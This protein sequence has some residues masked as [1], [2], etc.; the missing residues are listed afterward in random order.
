MTKPISSYEELRGFLANAAGVPNVRVSLMDE[1]NTS[2]VGIER[3][4]IA[5]FRQTGPMAANEAVEEA[6]KY[7]PQH[8]EL[9]AKVEMPTPDSS[10]H[11]PM[12]MSK[13]SMA[14][15]MDFKVKTEKLEKAIEELA[16]QTEQSAKEMIPNHPN[17]RSMVDH[18]VPYQKGD[19]VECMGLEG[20]ISTG[21]FVSVASSRVGDYSVTW[22]SEADTLKDL[23]GDM[24]NSSELV[25]MVE[26]GNSEYA[27][28][29]S[30]VQ[31]SPE[32]LTQI[33]GV[34]PS[35][36]QVL[37]R[38]D[39]TNIHDLRKATQDEL[40]QI[41]GIGNAL[42]ARIKADAGNIETA[43][44][45]DDLIEVAKICPECDENFQED[46]PEAIEGDDGKWYCSLECLNQKYA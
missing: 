24:V 16:E 8:I 5:K 38:N 21:T 31:F 33:G 13:E 28:P 37:E 22:T 23:W 30:K 9:E 46:S 41:E 40:A 11:E 44:D 17:S 35:K 20:Q 7:L 14:T 29:N 2:D 15:D 19:R 42:A 34:G 3:T 12:E 26:M 18:E 43:P 36:A 25:I 6:K 27:Y 45:P 4:I 1:T 32:S 10:T 39:Y